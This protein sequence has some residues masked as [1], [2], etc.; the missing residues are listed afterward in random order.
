MKLKTLI[1]S[2]FQNIKKEVAFISKSM[3][4][5][6]KNPLD[7]I[8]LRASA[9]SMTAIYNG[10]EK[11]LVQI[12]FAKG[13]KIKESFS[14]HTEVLKVAMNEKIITEATQKELVGFLSF[15]HFIR[16]TY[17]FEINP[18]TVEPILNKVQ[19]I[20][21]IFHKEIELKLVK[22]LKNE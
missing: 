9:L 6:G 13:I 16:H 12:L 8:L 11:I 15:R 19:A 20:T 18:S 21:D 5:K 10:I 1:D 14:W 22:I 7:D 2:E 4:V 3:E 17:S